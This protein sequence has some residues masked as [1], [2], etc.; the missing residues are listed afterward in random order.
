MRFFAFVV[1][2]ACGRAPL[3]LGYTNGGIISV[4]AGTT[5]TPLMPRVDNGV[6]HYAVQPTLPDGMALDAK[7]GILSGTPTTPQSARRYLVVATNDKGLHSVTLSIAVIASLPANFAYATPDIVTTAGTAIEDAPSLAVSGARFSTS[8]ALP[9]GMT[10]D[11]ASGVIDGAPSQ[12]QPL[13]T[14]VV[15]ASL[16][17]DHLASTTTSA[18][19]TITVN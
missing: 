13:T 9:V 18:L 14:Y 12:A 11:A 10:I 2:A 16:A 15:T 7:T 8:P 1:L 19:V 3:N 17:G 6:K 5:I 4:V